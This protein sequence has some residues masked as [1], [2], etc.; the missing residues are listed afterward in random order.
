MISRTALIGSL[1]RKDAQLFWPFAGLT[2]LLFALSKFPPAIAL[3]GPVGGLVS[4]GTQFAFVL[5]I[6]VVFYEDAVVSVR[7]DWLTRPVPG[8]VLLAAKSV[9]IFLAVLVPS[10]VGAFAHSLVQGG[11]LLEALAQASGTGAS[12]GML[13][14]VALIMSFAAVTSSIRQA[15]IVI[16]AII[17]A[18]AVIAALFSSTI[19]QADPVAITP[20]AWVL[21]RSTQLLV[22]V[23]AVSVLWVQYRKRHSRAARSI[24]VAAVMVGVAILASVNWTRA[25]AVQRAFAPEKMAPEALLA[26]ALPAGCFRSGRVERPD[27][28]SASDGEPSAVRPVTFRTS[29]S[30]PVAEPDRRVV[31][32]FV[33]VSWH[34]DGKRLYRIAGGAHVPRGLIGEHSPAAERTW[35]LP[36]EEYRRLAA[37]PG[38]ETRVDYSLSVLAPEA[39]AELLADGE[40][41]Y[42]GGIG[43]CGATVDRARGAVDVRCYVPGEQPAQ[44]A[45]T[46]VGAPATETRT[47]GAPEYTPAAIDFWGGATHRMKPAY[48]GTDVPRV[49]VVAYEARAHFDHRE[50]V[51]GVLGG[52]VSAC[53]AP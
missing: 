18:M 35:V 43:W 29:L 24:A 23:A 34:G 31:V 2:A 40:R 3:L 15:F 27:G 8:G 45:A 14:A 26:R 12:G 41:R 9:F 21:T 49:R 53:P 17:V 33:K 25:A 5:L 46:V 48:Q 51:P 28:A 4:L 44:I 13:M 7:H 37:V 19:S 30:G 47:S 32:D 22:T 1:L 50:V 52:P 42:Y 11:S 36:N 6:L 10:M 20:S 38:I 16:L 39:T